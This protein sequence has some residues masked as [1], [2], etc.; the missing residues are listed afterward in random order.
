M[1]APVKTAAL[2]SSKP[3]YKAVPLLPPLA[4][5]PRGPLKVESNREPAKRSD[6]KGSSSS[7]SEQGSQEEEK[8]FLR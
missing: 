5:N 3:T 1:G 6:R 4:F 2:P 8:G 7:S